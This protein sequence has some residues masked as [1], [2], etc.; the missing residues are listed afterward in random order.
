MNM[1]KFNNKAVHRINQRFSLRKISIGLVSVLLGTTIYLSQTT[2]TAQAETIT[3]PK[4]TQT[5][6]PQ[7]TDTETNQAK[8]ATDNSNTDNNAV[9]SSFKLDQP[10][11]VTNKAAQ[12][13]P[14][15]NKTE[16]S[17]T[18]DTN[19]VATNDTQNNKLKSDPETP[20]DYTATWNNVQIDYNHATQTLKVHG[21]KMTD[22]KSLAGNAK[23][24][25]QIK[26]I[27][28]IDKITLSGDAINMFGDLPNLTTITG[29]ENLDTKYVTSMKSMFANDPKL[30]SLDLSSWDTSSCLSMSSMFKQDSSLTSLNVKGFNTSKTE[31]MQNMFQGTS[32]LAAIDVS[33]FDT[34]SV[35]D[36]SYMFADMSN[37]STLNLANFTVDNFEFFMHTFNNDTALTS[38]DLSNFVTSSAT[39]F[40]YMFNN[41]ANLTSL[42]LTNFDTSKAIYLNDMFN[43]V[44]KLT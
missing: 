32:K 10:Q 11:T 26:Q 44:S 8:I 7:T 1:P 28:I 2:H 19:Q 18:A 5:D 34:S 30:T 17:K 31:F 6:A 3:D 21:G 15:I 33:S 43:I 4:T 23:Y 38:L 41:C 16:S 22:P 25:D 20:S 9:I 39:D 24:T 40:S 42:N 37:L 29:L 35:K 36:M 13:D 14:V 12:A 27:D